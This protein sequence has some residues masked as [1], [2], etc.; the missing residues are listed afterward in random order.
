MSKVRDRIQIRRDSAENWRIA[1]PILAAGEYGLELDTLLVKIGNG[2]TQWNNLRYLNKLNADYFEY[3]ENGEIGFNTEFEHLLDSFIKKGETIE[4]LTISNTPT[5]PNEIA[6]KQYV[7]EA[8]AAIGMLTR[9]VVSQLPAV[10]D[11]RDNVIYLIKENNIYT[12][13][14]LINGQMEQIGSGATI[15]PVATS[16]ELGGVKS[17]PDIS[18]GQDGFMTINRVSTSTLYVPDGDSFTIYSG[19]AT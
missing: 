10:A 19:N 3:D 17:S 9:Q 2:S 18:V 15:L 8:I 7:D 1:N 4:Q 6:N 14:M 13:Y 12:E 5:L 16:S 11:A